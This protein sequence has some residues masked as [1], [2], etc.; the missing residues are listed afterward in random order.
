MSSNITT[1]HPSGT[2]GIVMSPA[3]YELVKD[4]VLATMETHQSVN[5]PE[6]TRLV[7]NELT[8][9]IK[10]DIVA[11]VKAVQNDLE[12]KGLLE[13]KYRAGQH[14]VLLVKQPVPEV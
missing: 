14:L 4:N 2:Q 1:K 10:G 7:Y 6:L 8:G 13:R 5:M 12:T 9:K 11:L 3:D